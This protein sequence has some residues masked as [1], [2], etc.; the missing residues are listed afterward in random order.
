MS[1]QHTA[2]GHQEGAGREKTRKWSFSL[3]EEERKRERERDKERE[4]ILKLNI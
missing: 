4:N 3:A 1:K 2:L